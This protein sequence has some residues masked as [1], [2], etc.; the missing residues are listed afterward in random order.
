MLDL[1]RDRDWF[2]DPLIVAL[3][4][5]AAIGFAAFIIWELTEEYPVVNLRVFRYRGY[6]YSVI[7]LTLCWGAYF[8]SIIATPQWLQVSMG[9]T[10]ALAGI[11]TAFTSITAVTTAPLAARLMLRVDPRLLGSG[12]LIWLGIMS[13]VRAQWNSGADFW[14]LAM[15]QF[16]QGFALP[17]MIIPLTSSSISAVPASETAS[18]AGLQSFL[19]TMAVA[20]ATSLVLTQW[21]NAQRVSTNELAGSL[22]PAETQRILANAGMSDVQIPQVIANL[23]DKEALSVALNQTSLVAAGLM[24]LAAGIVWL[25]PRPASVI[26]ATVH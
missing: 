24:F 15:P 12:A 17:F 21:S 18:A 26:R 1:G 3:G 5:L 11:V 14:A 13:L 7:T 25:G 9:Y 20:M 22:Q 16:V 8:S 4:A 6:T 10:A 19:R 2:A 23:V